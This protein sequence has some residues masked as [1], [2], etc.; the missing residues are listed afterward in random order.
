MRPPAKRFQD[1]AFVAG[2]SP[3]AREA[4]ERLQAR[5]EYGF[6]LEG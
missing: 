1:I 6:M 3:E 2:A 4:H 5:Y